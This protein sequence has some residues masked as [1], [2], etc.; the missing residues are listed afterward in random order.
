MI[1][2]RAVSPLIATIILITLTVA[3]GAIL[4]NFGMTYVKK[5]IQCLSYDISIKDVKVDYNTNTLLVTLVNN[6]MEAINISK[7]SPLIFNAII[8]EKSYICEYN[9]VLD[10]R[11]CIIS[12]EVLLEPGKISTINIK[13]SQNIDLKGFRSGEFI[14]RGCG[15]IGET[16]YNYFLR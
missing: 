12:T 5:K 7:N 4:V 3:I 9:P 8:N 15:K 2:K 1:G 10:T 16:I 6:G 11:D 14:I 13:F